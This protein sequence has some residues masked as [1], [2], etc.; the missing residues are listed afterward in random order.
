MRSLF[1]CSLS[2]VW[3]VFLTCCL[4]TS[5]G[6]GMDEKNYFYLD[7]NKADKSKIVTV[8]GDYLSL[9]Y[10]DVYGKNQS[11]PLKIYN[12]KNEVVAELSLQKTMGLNYFNMDLTTIPDVTDGKIR[13]CLVIDEGGTVYE[14][15][16]RYQVPEKKDL[17]VAIFVNPKLIHC[18]DPLLG[19]YVEFYGSVSNG[20]APY[21]V[22]WYVMNANRTDYLYQPRTQVMD[23]PGSSAVIAVD[24]SPDYYVIMVVNDACGNEQYQVSQVTC[25]QGK[26]K[27]NTVFF[28]NID[29]VK[30]LGKKIN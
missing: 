27:I 9:Q 1:T 28:E 8:T 6:Q 14:L 13:S 21:T 30:N 24:I 11:L 3:I 16:F 10:H 7:L 4:N 12:W 15:V 23:R 18:D 22:D 17:A 2:F 25:K 19:N 5:S 20:N 26:K 29:Q